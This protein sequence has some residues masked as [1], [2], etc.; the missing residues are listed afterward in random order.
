VEFP[1]YFGH[2]KV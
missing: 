2:M 1:F